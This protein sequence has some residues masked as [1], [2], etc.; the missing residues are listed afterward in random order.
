MDP[1]RY[2]ANAYP[3]DR[4]EVTSFTRLNAYKN[5]NKIKIMIIENIS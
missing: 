4:A 1:S 2:S 5:K 3:F